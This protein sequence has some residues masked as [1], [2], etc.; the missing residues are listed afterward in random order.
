[1]KSIAKFTML[2]LVLATMAC[3]KDGDGPVDDTDVYAGQWI[4]NVSGEDA[5]TISFYIY[6]DG[7]LTGD[8][9]TGGTSGSIPLN[10]KVSSS[11]KISATFISE[12]ISGSVNGELEESFGDG[13]W[14][15]SSNS[16]KGSWSATKK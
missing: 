12:A 14:T 2:F 11:G 16:T 8:F 4:G 7:G 6:G 9:F 1:M 13:S 5:G 10:G 15:I 3:S